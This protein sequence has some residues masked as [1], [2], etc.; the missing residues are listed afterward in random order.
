MFEYSRTLKRVAVYAILVGAYAALPVWKEH[1]VFH[2]VA[3]LPTQ[4]HAALTLVLGWLLVF[5]TNTAYARWWE[6]RTLWS[7][8]VNC[9]RNI[10]VKL[11]TLLPVGLGERDLFRQGIVGFAY[12]LRDHL[13][14]QTV[15]DCRSGFASEADRPVHL[16]AYLVEQMYQQ[17]G[18]WRAEK[19]LQGDELRVLDEELRRFLDIC[20]SCERIRNTRLAS[21]YRVFARQCVFL[22]LGTF[23]WGIVEDFG[24]WTIP[25]T[26]ITAYFMLGLE[27]VAE[28]VEEPFGEDDDDIDLD[29]LCREIECTVGEIFDREPAA[30]QAAVSAPLLV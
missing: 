9:S 24:W 11:N 17:L 7:G 5:R 29:A 4:I 10:A 15:R 23:P 16:P 26:M 2:N 3:D 6:A 25:L 14:D 20:G 13:R 28:Q 8:L 22:F 18:R 21:S 19:Q 12:A 27:T 1:T 30:P